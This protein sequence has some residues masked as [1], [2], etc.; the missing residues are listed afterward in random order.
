MR[1]Y[2]TRGVSKGDKE[3]YKRKIDLKRCHM[4]KKGETFPINT[5]RSSL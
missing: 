5:Q 4:I 1:Q 3:R 2:G